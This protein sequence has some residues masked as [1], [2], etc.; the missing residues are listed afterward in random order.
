MA[1]STALKDFIP[2][3]ELIL[4]LCNSLG[5]DH[6][7]VA[8]I[9]SSVWEDNAGCQKLANLEMPRMAPRSKHYAIKYHW[10][11]THLK[12]NNMIVERIESKSNIANIFTKGFAGEPFRALR[13]ILCGW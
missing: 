13:L 2:M 5:L 3:R 11:W 12:P 7:K 10:F 4:K 1:L 8:T 6:Q 9:K